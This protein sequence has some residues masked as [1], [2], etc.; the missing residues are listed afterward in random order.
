MSKSTAKIGSIANVMPLPP[1]MGPEPLFRIIIDNK[2]E[3][4]ADIPSVHLPKL[5]VGQAA[6]ARLENGRE[7]ASEIRTILPEIDRKT[8]L[9]KVRLT[10]DNDPAIRAGMFVGGA[11]EASHSCGVSIPPVRRGISDGRVDGSDRAQYHRGDPPRWA[12]LLLRRRHRGER[13]R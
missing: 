4:E 3:I 5:K 13:R 11:I 1:P 2:L 10:V 6:R 8:Q 9:G 12:W 7:I